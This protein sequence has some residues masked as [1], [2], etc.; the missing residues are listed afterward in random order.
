[1]TYSWVQLAHDHWIFWLLILI[2]LGM[3]KV[4][5]GALSLW[6]CFCLWKELS[7]LLKDE[8][9]REK[10]IFSQDDMQQETS[11]HF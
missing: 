10:F 11:E 1:M 4:A 3:I 9:V 6:E 2:H 8:A 5:G 7:F